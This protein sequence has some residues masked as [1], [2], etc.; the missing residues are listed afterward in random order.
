[1]IKL[2]IFG[3]S[4]RMG[5]RIAFCSG[6]DPEVEI[7]GGLEVEGNPQIGVDFGRVAGIEDIDVPIVSDVKAA[8]ENAD[9][10][11]D[12][13]FHQ[14]TVKNLSEVAELNKPIVIGTTGFS[15]DE[16][17]QIKDFSNRIPILLA[18]NMSLGVNLVFKLVGQIATALGD[19]YDIEIVEAHHNQKKDAPSGTAK[20]IAEKIA[21]ALKRNL[22]Q[23]AVH[24]RQGIVG[25]RE[26]GQIG[27]HAVRGGDIVGDHT[28]IYA[29]PGER[30]ELKHQAHSRDTFARGALKAAKFIAGKTPGLYGMD[31]VLGI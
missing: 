29:G 25:E 20:K 13:S 19:E 31:D 28:I 10:V 8:A 15:G 27:I 4:G 12:F 22:D 21:E 26:T 11:I 17:A 6:D 1:M 24:G 3:A 9:V 7:T 30:I 23:V 5:R 2:T 16:L 14:A 18:P